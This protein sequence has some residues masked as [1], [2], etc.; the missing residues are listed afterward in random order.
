[1]INLIVTNS[2]WSSIAVMT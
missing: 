2:F 1:M